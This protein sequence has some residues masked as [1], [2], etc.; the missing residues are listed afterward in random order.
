MFITQCHLFAVS[1]LIN[2]AMS[3]Q[4]FSQFNLSSS[5]SKIHA[6]GTSIDRPVALIPAQSPRYVPLILTSRITASSEWCVLS[7]SQL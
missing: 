3:K 7:I 6:T 1:W 2:V 4:T 5:N